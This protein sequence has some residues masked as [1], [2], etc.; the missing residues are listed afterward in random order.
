[1]LNKNNHLLRLLVL[2]M[3]VLMLILPTY[4]TELDILYIISPWIYITCFLFYTRTIQHK[5]EWIPFCTIYLTGCEIRYYSFLGNTGDNFILISILLIIVLATATVLP[6]FVDYFYMKKGYTAGKFLALP[7]VRL[8]TENFII[9]KQFNL[10]LSQFGNKF[11]IQSA[12]FLGDSFITILVALIPSVIV[13]M[14]I[15]KDNKKLVKRGMIILGILPVVMIL[16]GLRYY[17]HSTPEDKILMAYATGPQKVYYE[18]PSKEEPGY[19]ENLAYLKRTIKE[20]AAKNAKLI[21]YSEEAFGIN[22]SE[23][24]SLVQEVQKLAKEYNIYVLICLDTIEPDLYENK[25]VFISNEGKYLSDYL[26][27]NLIPVVEDN[28][29]KAG[30]GV[31]PANY[32]TIDGKEMVIS[33][34]ICYDATFS[35]FLATMDKK[36]DLYINPSWDWAEIDDLNYRLQGM[37]AVENGVELF[38]P[39]VDGWSIVTD[40]YGKLSYKESTLGGDYDKVYF[41]EVS[42]GRTWTPYKYYSMI[43][44]I[45]WS[46]LSALLLFDIA[47]ILLPR[48]K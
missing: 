45:F 32:V 10:S 24:E 4:N 15:E 20:A 44:L 18:N 3:G 37:S 19:E 48:K 12:A 39:T 17:L 16:G 35:N 30:N 21:A 42:T 8:V 25:A 2:L 5:L 1:M 6:Y 46:L 47:R 7:I 26:K 29:Y 23:E 31:I 14:L 27:T 41:T 38:K 36:T 40:P 13:Y 28:E 33:Y 34:T 22:S 9:G 11:L 43:I